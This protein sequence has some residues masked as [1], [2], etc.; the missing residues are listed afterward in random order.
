MAPDTDPAPAPRGGFVFFS[1]ATYALGKEVG[2]EQASEL[3]LSMC[4]DPTPDEGTLPAARTVARL[5]HLEQVALWHDCSATSIGKSRSRAAFEAHK[6]AADVWICCDDDVEA[7][8][9]TLQ[10]LIGAARSSVRPCV[11]LAPCVTRGSTVVNV[12]LERSGLQRRE[13]PGG[14]ATIPCIAGGFG[15]VAMNRGALERMFDR[16]ANTLSFVDDDGVIKVGLFIEMLAPRVSSR[17]I[18]PRAN[19]Q[20]WTGEDVSFC[21]RA[22]DAGVSLEALVSGVTSH[23]GVALRLESVPALGELEP[24]ASGG[25]R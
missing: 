12:A 18:L 17:I 16:Y 11:V 15:L 21:R 14:G 24:V 4:A 1:T 23:A 20:I 6:S 19:E 7:D 8:S 13:L 2:F 5:Q 25:A 9:Q 10:W 22:T 3:F